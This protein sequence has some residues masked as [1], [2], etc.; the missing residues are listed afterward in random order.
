MSDMY[1]L[2]P[3]RMRIPIDGEAAARLEETITCFFISIK[4]YL[5]KEIGCK[6]DH[7]RIEYQCYE[8]SNSALR[9]LVCVDYLIGA[10]FVRRTEFNNQ[11]AAFS[12]H[13]ECLEKLKDRILGS[14]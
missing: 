9:Y 13:L 7:L 12:L 11:E 2:V 10:V 1:P 3:E 6:I 8:N 4:E 14:R 5:A